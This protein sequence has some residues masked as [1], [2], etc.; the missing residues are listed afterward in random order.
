MVGIYKFTNKITGEVYVGQSVDLQKRYNQHKNRCSKNCIKHEDTYFHRQLAHYGWD[1]FDYE[2]IE[3]CKISELNDKEMYYIKLFN[4]QYPKGYNL[5]KG[6]YM[7]SAQK[8]TD[9]EVAQIKDELLNTEVEEQVIAD[10]HGVILNTVS[11]INRG[12]MWHDEDRNYPIRKQKKKEYFCSKCGRKLSG[13][14][15]TGL[16]QD[17]YKSSEEFIR[18]CRHSDS[19][20]I[21]RPSKE[22]LIELLIHN[23]FNGVGKMFGV[24]GNSIRKWCDKY[25]IPRYASYY[26]SLA[27]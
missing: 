12:K 14:V 27:V 5:S 23:S 15:K 21:P 2:V 24:D 13:K 16:C 7:P 3:E 9:E 6:G 20:I 26:K 11:L 8:L 17:C 25:N 10:N 4:S 18:S 1:N 19:D 22:D